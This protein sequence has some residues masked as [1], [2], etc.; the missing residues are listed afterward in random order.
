MRA[1]NCLKIQDTD[2]KIVTF[3]LTRTVLHVFCSQNHNITS[4]RLLLLCLFDIV[5]KAYP[6]D[7]I[8]MTN[9]QFIDSW[10]LQGGS[11]I[12]QRVSNVPFGP[13]LFVFN[14]ITILCKVCTSP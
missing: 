4:C 13:D 2:K 9:S 14:R 1:L 6:K 11:R 7:V 3:V 12:S 10:L 8:T 5:V